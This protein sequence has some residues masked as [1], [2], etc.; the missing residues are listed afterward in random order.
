MYISMPKDFYVP[1]IFSEEFKV[2]DKSNQVEYDSERSKK[3]ALFGDNNTKYSIEDLEKLYE[4]IMIASKNMSCADALDF[5]IK[6]IRKILLSHIENEKCIESL[7]DSKLA[8]LVEHI[9]NDNTDK[10]KGMFQKTDCCSNKNEIDIEK[11]KKEN[12]KLLK[13]SGEIYSTI[14]DEYINEVLNS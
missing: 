4:G 7:K 8:S 11:Y 13:E 10:Y 9:L 14:D 5:H 2:N 3:K 6:H 1:V 12:Q